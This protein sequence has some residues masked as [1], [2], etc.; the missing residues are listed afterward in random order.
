MFSAPYFTYDGVFSGTYGLVIA[1]FNAESV[2]ETSVFSPVFRTTKP[3]NLNRFI[4][5]GIQ[6]DTT[7][8]FQFSIISETEIPD[9]VRREILSWL[10]G[11]NEFKRL[12]IHQTDLERYHYNC[13]FAD[14]S[15]IFVH[16][17][18]HGFRVTAVF[19]SPFAYGEPTVVSIQEAGEHTITIKNTSD[20]RD[21][22]VYPKVTF[23]GSGITIINNTDD[24]T[25]E[26]NFQDLDGDEQIVV[27]NEVKYISSNKEK[28]R[29]KN[30]NKKWLR[31]RKGNNELTIISQGAVTIE[32]PCYVM[33]GF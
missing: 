5:S 7:P 11:R 9:I 2:V 27:D 13:V 29:L 32:C 33:I 16:G 21:A 24:E 14:A 31:L 6:Y 22:Y 15:I 10:V 3:A 25:R 1:D 20:L 30:F 4:H 23:A 19:D 18:C 8:Q 17:R 28:T 26:F 12:E